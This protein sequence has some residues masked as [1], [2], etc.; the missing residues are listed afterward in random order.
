M[1]FF[2]GPTRQ[3]PFCKTRFSHEFK[4]LI[5]IIIIIIFS[6]INYLDLLQL[7]VWIWENLDK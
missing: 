6:K 2:I 5:I 7:F 3:K 1:F 4:R